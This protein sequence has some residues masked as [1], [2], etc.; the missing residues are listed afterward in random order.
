MARQ[1]RNYELKEFTAM[2]LY[3][4]ADQA[5]RIIFPFQLDNES[6][7]PRVNYAITPNEVFA[8]TRAEDIEGQPILILENIQSPEEVN[9]LV[10]S[11]FEYQPIRGQFFLSVAGYNLSIELETSLKPNDQVPNVVFNLTED[12]RKHLIDRDVERLR[13]SMEAEFGQEKERLA[14]RAQDLAKDE[15]AKALLNEPDRKWVRIESRSDDD[16]LVYYAEQLVNYSVTYYGLHF[17]LFNDGPETLFIDDIEHQAIA[18]DSQRLI[19]GKTTCLGRL[20]RAEEKRCILVSTDSVLMQAKQIRGGCSDSGR[21]QGGGVVKSIWSVLLVLP[22]VA[23]A[24]GQ[25]D[26]FTPDQLQQL[27]DQEEAERWEA[28]KRLQS[29]RGE[30]GV[31]NIDNTFLQFKVDGRVYP[32]VLLP[33]DRL[34]PAIVIDNERRQPACID[35]DYQLHPGVYKPPIRGG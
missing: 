15:L 16:A 14:E 3:L 10:N 32:G 8:V 11:R 33:N 18:G 17:T 22:F 20:D 6:F 4:V 25:S 23:W 1:Y 26:F 19:Q 31:R 5:T 27:S 2:K 13:A 12:D 34:A 29:L 21:R 35:Q 7:T 24:E 9:A 30:E 28:S